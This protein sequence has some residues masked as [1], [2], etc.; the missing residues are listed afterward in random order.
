MK[1]ILLRLFRILAKSLL[2]IYIVAANVAFITLYYY[3]LWAIVD[4]FVPQA[5]HHLS[6]AWHIPMSVLVFMPLILVV[7]YMLYCVSPV[8]LWVL[9]TREGFVPLQGARK[10][11][12]D[13]LLAEMKVEGR[14]TFYGNDSLRLNAMAFGTRSIG[15]TEG[16]F[17]TFSNEELKGVISHELGHIH[18]HDFIYSSLVYSLQ[19]PGSLALWGIFQIPIG[20]FRFLGTLLGH[21]GELNGFCLLAIRL[22]ELAYAGIVLIVYRLCALVDANINKYSEYRCGAGLLSALRRIQELEIANDPHRMTFSE[23]MMSTHPSTHKRIDR[24]GQRLAAS[25]RPGR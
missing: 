11:L 2:L 3:V 18:H 22:L 14:Y 25:A 20:F 16:A 1:R 6:A 15:L 13:G 17:R 24:I 21:N 7:L 19:R 10:S 23:Y 8:N 4:L 5:M 12:I 9:R